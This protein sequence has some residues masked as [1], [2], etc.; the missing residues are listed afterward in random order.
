VQSLA[1]PPRHLLQDVPHAVYAHRMAA[2]ELA[3]VLHAAAADARF[4]NLL[5]HGYAE[6]DD[7]RVVDILQERVDD[8]AAF[9]SALARAGG[10]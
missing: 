6:I 5:V 10:G 8:P 4:R 7:T 1:N 3:A 2:A 9:R